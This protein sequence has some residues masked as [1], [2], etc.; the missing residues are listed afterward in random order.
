MKRYRE[1][2]VELVYVLKKSAAS[3]SLVALLVET[4]QTEGVFIVDVKGLSLMNLRRRFM[5]PH[6]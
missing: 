2:Q 6:L 3:S 1:I 5:L 4:K